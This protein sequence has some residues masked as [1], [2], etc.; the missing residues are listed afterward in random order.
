MVSQRWPFVLH[1][2]TRAVLV[3]L[4]NLFRSTTA[5]DRV[6]AS[7]VYMSSNT[8]VSALNH[9]DDSVTWNPNKLNSTRHG[10]YSLS[11]SVDCKL[12]CGSFVCA[13]RTV[14]TGWYRWF[15]RKYTSSNCMLCL[16]GFVANTRYEV[17]PKK[18]EFDTK[19]VKAASSDQHDAVYTT[20]YFPSTNQRSFYCRFSLQ[21]ADGNFPLHRYQR[22]VFHPR[23]SVGWLLY[24]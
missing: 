9:V 3:N 11:H 24:V 19:T 10:K 13:E 2:T 7:L 4:H 23:Q 20:T 17:M 12:D 8:K 22:C 5:H 18:S 21:I 15:F 6:N 1:D 16:A 14:K